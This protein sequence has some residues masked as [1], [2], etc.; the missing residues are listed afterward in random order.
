MASHTGD[1][2]FLDARDPLLVNTPPA[3]TPLE[4]PSH[5]PLSQPPKSS[6]PGEHMNVPDT[7]A[8]GRNA[9]LTLGTDSLIVFGIHLAQTSRLAKAYILQMKIS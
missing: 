5:D 6:E 7:L 8:V 9:L 1:D 4:A 2:P 3:H